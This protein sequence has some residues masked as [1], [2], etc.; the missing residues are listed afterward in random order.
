MPVEVSQTSVVE[1]EF[2]W[3][4]FRVSVVDDVLSSWSSGSTACD[5]ASAE[6]S[7]EGFAVYDVFTDTLDRASATTLFWPEMCLMS[8]ENSEI[9]ARCLISR[10]EC[11]ALDVIAYVSGLWSV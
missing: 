9:K 1:D 7:M 3:M 11:V 2:I 10:G 5:V 6:K 8:V 4:S